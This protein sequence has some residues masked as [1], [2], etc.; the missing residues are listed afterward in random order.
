MNTP[1]PFGF[2]ILGPATGERRLVEAG[3]AFAAYAGCDERAEVKR[4]A[5]FSAFQYGSDFRQHLH[6]FGSVKGFDGECWARWVWFDVDRTDLNAALDDARRLA[7]YIVERYH[8]DDT[9]L[10]A[11]FSGSK[12]FHLGIPTS[13]WEPEPSTTFHRIARSF[14]ECIAQN[15]GVA[16]D[17]GVYDKVRLF[18]APN[19]RHPKTGWH[20]RW[21]SLEQL[22]GLSFDDIVRLAEAPAAFDIP[23]SPGRNDHAAA[24]W[25]A[26]WSA[27]HRKAEV[28]AD[29]R[30]VGTPTL[31]RSTVDFIL[32]GAEVGDRHRLLFS[33]AANLAEFGCPPALAH[34][35]L[36]EAGLN[37][38]LP[39]S[40]VKRQI[41]CGLEGGVALSSSTAASPPSVTPKARPDFAAQLASIWNRQPRPARDDSSPYV[42]PPS[43][44]GVDS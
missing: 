14:A 29:R 22:R 8:L 9:V 6:E 42:A 39:P 11:F 17:D 40:E 31:N 35:L 33:A 20:K 44:R 23:D 18:R 12:G 26:A 27:V 5:Y 10:L 2:R 34:A 28:M 15:A 24:D 19:S 3:P 21:L 4:E 36:T 43:Y 41:N 7:S 13:L 38:G 1:C 16:I 25:S 37:S 30:A 32:K